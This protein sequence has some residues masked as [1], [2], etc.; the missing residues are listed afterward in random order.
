LY[1]NDPTGQTTERMVQGAVAFNAALTRWCASSDIAVATSG[2]FNYAVHRD[3][4]VDPAAFMAHCRRVDD[5]LAPWRHALRPFVT[6]DE[7]LSATEL[8][9]SELAITYDGAK[10]CAA[11]SVPEISLDP[12]QVSR[13]LATCVLTHPRIEFVPRC[14]VAS[15]EESHAGFRVNVAYDTD[16][17]DGTGKS[18]TLHSL[19]VVNALWADRL[20][21]DACLGIVPIRPWMFRYKLAAHAPI[22]NASNVAASTTYVLGPFGDFVNFGGNKAYLSWYPKGRIG[23]S[24][25]LSPT[26]WYPTL[27]AALKAEIWE[28]FKF[29]LAALQPGIADIAFDEANVEMAGGVI[30]SW[31]HG[32]VH[33]HESAI[34]QRF[35]IGV[36][37][38]GGYHTIDTG[39]WGMAAL[40]AND[41]A[42]RID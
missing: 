18:E 3:T 23:V 5:T 21:I 26:D 1:A 19:V 15:I 42:A 32:D 12:E 13:S 22:R 36:A 8:P 4:L 10:I 34:H 27:T 31:G 11:V 33:I 6:C 7:Q 20:R 9:P 29:E 16:D 35:D 30:F 24:H 41:L 40:F 25:E 17:S 28:A 37:S 38:Y 39:K 14:R 2:P